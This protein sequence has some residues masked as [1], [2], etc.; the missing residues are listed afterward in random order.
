MSFEFAKELHEHM[1][2][3]E[4][5]QQLQQKE[6]QSPPV[7][8]KPIGI[9]YKMSKNPVTINRNLFDCIF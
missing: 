9:R 4:G 1:K 6:M 8:K 3:H 2:K 7:S 5:K